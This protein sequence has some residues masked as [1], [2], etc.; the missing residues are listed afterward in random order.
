MSVTIIG[1]GPGDID[2]LSLEH[3]E[4]FPRKKYIVEQKNISGGYS[5]RVRN[6]I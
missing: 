2:N 4:N 1:L 5:T 6:T 3:I